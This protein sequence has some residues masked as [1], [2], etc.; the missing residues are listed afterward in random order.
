MNKDSESATGLIVGY[1]RSS[2]NLLTKTLQQDDVEAVDLETGP[3]VLLREDHRVP[4][5]E[6]Q[7][8]AKVGSADE[9]ESESGIAHFHEH[10]LFKGTSKRGVGK[11]ATDIEKNGGYINAYTS[12][13]MTVYHT[14]LPSSQ[15]PIGL[16]VLADITQNSLFAEEEVKREI[17][18]VLEEIRRSE[19]TP[20]HVLSDALFALAYQRHPYGKPILG[21]PESVRT[22]S[23]E[24]VRNFYKRWYQPEN[25]MIVAVGDFCGQVLLKKIESAFEKSGQTPLVRERPAE[26]ALKE[27]FRTT[28]LNRQFERGCLEMCWP[29]VAFNHPDTPSLDLLAFIL[30]EGESSRLVRRLR[31]ELQLAD[32]IDASSYTPLDAGLFG[33]NADF[34]PKHCKSLVRAIAT[35][36]E[37]LRNQ[38]VTSEELEKAKANFLAAEFWERESVSGQA[39]KLGT[40]EL[41]SGSYRKERDYLSSIQSATRQQLLEV[42]NRWLDSEKT[43]IA[44]V[45][46]E[47]PDTI[48][49]KEELWNCVTDGKAEARS[50]F[51]KPKKLQQKKDVESFELDSGPR[52][53]VIKR[54]SLPIFSLRLA[55]RGGLISEKRGTEGIS[56]FLAGMWLRGTKRRSSGEFA[57]TVESMAG[58]IDSFSGRNSTGLSIDGPSENRSKFLD[59]LAETLMEPA[60]SLT[61]IERERTDTLA[62]LARR[63]D[64]L[65]SRAF[66]LFIQTL[67][68]A[69]PYR[70]PVLGSQE[71]VNEI[72]KND[73]NDLHGSIVRGQNIDIACVGDVE[74]EELAD[75]MN[76]RFSQLSDKQYEGLLPKEDAPLDSPKEVE[77][78]IDRSQAH[79]VI[80][81]P[82]LRIT[83]PDRVYL[84]IV[85][86]ILGG[87]GGR[88]FLDLRDRKGL[89]YTVS[90]VSVEGLAPGYFAV[91]IA[92]APEK[93]DDARNGVLEQLKGII[94]S[95]PTDKEINSAKQSLIGSFYIGQQ[96]ASAQASH[97]A[98]DAC[99]GLGA[100]NFSDVP[101]KIASATREDI[102]TVANKIVDLKRYILAV[103]RP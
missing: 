44:T 97:I 16:D 69:H 78:Q 86:Q 91:Y 81:F 59:L 15:T 7:V 52:L 22:L 74:T 25:L 68:P 63:K 87:Q 5:A 21:D 56:Q 102:L 13:D 92:T 34:D 89:A 54:D 57:R 60:L 80:G 18:V 42:A 10:M 99:Y 41:L 58:D 50:R 1:S 24:R 49:E 100:G 46:P 45:L 14:T 11:V 9:D 85:S 31:E 30:G 43:L 6:I 28:L 73:L 3:R 98:L 53:H 79:L 4:V 55:M 94:D 82:G 51:R 19:D 66:D 17:E 90:A 38:P 71:T 96:R 88:L 27:N 67:Y 83:D 36:I 33:V 26:H 48:I 47:N 32:R 72:T 12:F 95:P 76:L 8:W 70:M 40:F 93:L 39:R 62:A 75:E 37:E 64:R 35:E 61:E 23:S 84:D 77:L 103:I 65:S 29:T 20:Q 101:E 2:V